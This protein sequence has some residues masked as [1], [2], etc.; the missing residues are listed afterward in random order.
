[1][2]AFPRRGIANNIQANVYMGTVD[3][4]DNLRLIEN[5]L[6]HMRFELDRESPSYFRIARE[7]H[8]LLYRTMIESLTCGNW[9]HVTQLKSKKHQPKYSSVKYLIGGKPWQEIRKVSI[10]GC[11]RAWRFSDPVICP[12]P[13]ESEIE[14]V[15]F[16]NLYRSLHKAK[17]IG[18]YDALAM[19]Q[20]ENFMSQFMFSKSIPISDEDMKTFEC[21]HKSIRNEYEH[22]IPKLYLA[23]THN[24]L[25][26]TELCLSV[27]RALLFESGNV[28]FHKVTKESLKEL[29]ESVFKEVNLLLRNSRQASKST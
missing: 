20:T 14:K 13:P 12:P 18:F 8:L 22:F 17:L 15:F 5:S 24:L 25:V 10:D 26:A 6:L 29:L 4:I 3:T 11:K 28:D 21:L 16:K 9:Q 23:P 19:I 27:S 7:A 2:W 1:M